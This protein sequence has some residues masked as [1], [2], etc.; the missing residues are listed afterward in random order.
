MLAHVMYLSKAIH[1]QKIRYD[2]CDDYDLLLLS[3]IK[4][5][6]PFVACVETLSLSDIIFVVPKIYKNHLMFLTYQ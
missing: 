5:N 6:T 2:G 1:S 4:N 3:H